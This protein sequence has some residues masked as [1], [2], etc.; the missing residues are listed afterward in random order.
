M[1]LY[2]NT[3]I[4]PMTT[5]H[6]QYEGINLYY[7]N[8]RFIIVT[9][10]EIVNGFP[11]HMLISNDN[12]SCKRAYMQVGEN[13]INIPIN[14]DFKRVTKECIKLGLK[15][16]PIKKKLAYDGDKNTLA[17]KAEMNKKHKK[18]NKDSDFKSYKSVKTI[19]TITKKTIEENLKAYKWKKANSKLISF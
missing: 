3:S 14:R 1:K 16:T 8:K 17:I 6:Y 11:L 12:K 2:T 18:I 9:D 15:V 13:Y 4:I 7:I 10:Y 19:K 5:K